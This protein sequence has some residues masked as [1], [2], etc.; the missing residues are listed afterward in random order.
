[1]GLSPDEMDMAH[2]YISGQNTA[3]IPD[4]VKEAV[5]QAKTEALSLIQE[6]YGVP[7][8]WK[9]ETEINEILNRT[10]QSGWEI[11]TQ[12]NALNFADDYISGINQ[13]ISLIPEGGDRTA[14]LNVLKT[15]ANAL[16]TLK[17]A[18]FMMQAQDAEIGGKYSKAE[19]EATMNK[20][21][22]EMKELKEIQEKK[23]KQQKTAKI[24]KIFSW[25]MAPLNLIGAS[26]FLG[27]ILACVQMV[28]QTIGEITDDAKLISNMFKAV[29]DL[30][31]QVAPHNEELQATFNVFVK[32]GICC[33]IGTSV[34]PLQ[35]VELFLSKSNT[36]KDIVLAI[37]GAK[38]SDAAWVQLAVEIAFM[39]ATIV[40]AIAAG[41]MDQSVKQV[42]KVM[43]IMTKLI[44]TAS[45]LASTMQAA[46]GG[47]NVANNIYQMQMAEQKGDL[48]AYLAQMQALIQ[49]LQKL[50]SKIL[51]GLTGIGQFSQEINATLGDIWQRSSQ[52]ATEIGGALRG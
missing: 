24:L 22:K 43:Q 40:G 6:R 13:Y 26:G 32:I 25:I 17:Q 1:M 8:N 48:D 42:G 37:P 3:S 52:S 36:I 47:V 9:T 29:E 44:Q 46:Q 41:R 51:N 27:M 11:K 38:E 31:K 18:V 30:A 4:S 34:N 39:I 16:T 19:F 10:T 23:R 35:S 7:S 20:L 15:I 49:V 33:G 50:A 2:A 28:E 5:T 12:Y 21:D 14:A 45:I